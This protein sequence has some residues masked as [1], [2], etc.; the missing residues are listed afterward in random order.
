MVFFSIC[1]CGRRT[2]PKPATSETPFEIVHG[3]ASVVNHSI[4]AALDDVPRV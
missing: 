2:D 3:T 1:I 4:D